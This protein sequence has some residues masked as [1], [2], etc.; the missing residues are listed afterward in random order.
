[1]GRDGGLRLE[2]LVQICTGPS[3]RILRARPEENQ[4]QEQAGRPY[5]PTVKGVRGDMLLQTFQDH[6][7]AELSRAFLRFAEEEGN[8]NGKSATVGPVKAG[9][10]H[11][12]EHMERRAS[13]HADHTE[14]S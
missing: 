10:S 2:L 1:M 5:W 3:Q 12:L 7:Q 6:L 9:G 4:T 8:H 14:R 13:R 11:R